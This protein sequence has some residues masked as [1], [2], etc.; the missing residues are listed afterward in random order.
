M[1][2]TSVIRM[3][4][5]DH[6]VTLAGQPMAFLVTGEHSQHTSMF[7]WTLPPRF[8][9][10]RHVH[11]VQEETFYMLDGQC[12]WQVGNETVRALP[13]TFV[14]IP[15]GVP[16]NIANVSEQPARVI[17]TVSPP[18]HEHYFEELARLASAGA[19]H[20]ARVIGDLRHRYDTDQ[21]S[22]LRADD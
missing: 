22:A 17:M 13:G 8:S 7:E 5:D 10:G 2:K 18:G 3:A 12:E 19:L 20:D 16:H 1:G 9:T 15:P 14:F 11:R 4:H 6:D 21:L